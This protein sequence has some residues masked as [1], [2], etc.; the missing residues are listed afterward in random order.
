MRMGMIGTGRIA[1]RF[2]A[3]VKA[4]E[5][6]E[7][8]C[9]YNPHPQ[10]AK[11]FAAKRGIDGYTDELSVFMNSGIDGVYI[12]APHGTH[13]EYIKAALTAGKHVL[14]EKPMVFSR[15]QAEELYRLADENGLIL[16]EAMKTAFCPGFLEIEKTVKSGLIGTVTDVEAA[17]TRLTPT[18]TREYL[19]P[20]YG[21]SFTEFGSYPLLPILRFL[22]TDYEKVEFQEVPA[23]NGTDGF[24]KAVFSFSDGCAA[25]KTGLTVKSEGQLVISGTRGYILVPSPWWLTRYFEV[26]FEDPGRIERH[27]CVF[28]EAGL[29]YEIRAFVEETGR[30]ADADSREIG[31]EDYPGVMSTA[32]R[33]E[34]ITRARVMEEFLKKRELKPFS[35]EALKRVRIWAHRGCSMNYPENTLP[36]FEAAAKLSGLCGI[37]LDVQRTKDGELVVIHDETVD[38]VTAGSGAVRDLTWSELA[39]L[40]IRRDE[41]AFYQGDMP[42]IPTFQ[43][44][45]S[46]LK[47][48]CLEKGLK[49]N[50][51][52]KTSIVRYEGIERQVYDMIR[53]FAL[54]EYVVYSSFLADSIRIMKEIDPGVET[55]MLAGEL[56]DCIRLGDEVRCDAYHPWAGGLKSVR[57]DKKSRAMKDGFPVRAWNGDEPL[58]GSGRTLP[59]LDIREYCRFGVTDIFTN[60]P[61]RYLG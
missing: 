46:L 48:Y 3:E 53:E 32:I 45:L 8:T 39:K 18:N 34:T 51:E 9:I 43:E 11:R 17:F 31:K 20:L 40:E 10:S 56:E 60:V 24:T 57:R 27:E 21:G 13:Y 26:R 5:G 12:A 4:V 61:E 54:Q 23:L 35:P 37:E 25:A 41:T 16:M 22:G 33:S 6:A 15:M 47:P 44:V 28:E 52:L 42:G 55:G 36:A 30:G 50:V 38:R 14:C 59:S 2:A 7:L 58:Y 1:G 19:D 49:I 29:R